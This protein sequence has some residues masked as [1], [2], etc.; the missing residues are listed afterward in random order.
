M[1]IARNMLIV[2]ALLFTVSNAHAVHMCNVKIWEVDPGVRTLIFE[3]DYERGDEIGGRRVTAIKDCT[4]CFQG[5]ET[6]GLSLCSTQGGE[7]YEL[8][9]VKNSGTTKGR[10]L[11]CP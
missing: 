8:T 1:T 3:Q 7:Q 4:V 5:G 11:N 9:C 6:E 10:I 2:F